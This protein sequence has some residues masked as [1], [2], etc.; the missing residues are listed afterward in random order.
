MVG[1]FRRLFR[2][3]RAGIRDVH[4]SNLQVGDNYIRIDGAAATETLYLPW[5]DLPAV[6]GSLNDFDIFKLLSWRTRICDKL[7]GREAEHND[8]VAWALAPAPVAVRIMS[9][10]GGAGKT[11]LAAQVAERLRQDGWEAGFSP[12][13]AIDPQLDFSKPQFIILDYPESHRLAVQAL[14]GLVGRLET[15]VAKAQVRVLMLSRLPLSAWFNDLEEAGVSG[16]A[17]SKGYVVKT[18]GG[19]HLP[20][21]RRGCEQA[22]DALPPRR[23]GTAR[24]P[25][26]R[27]A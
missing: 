8:L 12:L 20:N 24:G 10:E 3:N 26:R 6:A 18:L 9:G 23:A 1:A 22:K 16:R 5:D 4:G 27:L 25:G 13:R 19:G 17:E 11:R 21:R 7:V 2:A 15:G 14:L